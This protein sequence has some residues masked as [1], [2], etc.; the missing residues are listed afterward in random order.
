MRFSLLAPSRAVDLVSVNSEP[1]GCTWGSPK[2]Q[3]VEGMQGGLW[4]RASHTAGSQPLPRRLPPPQPGSELFQPE[5]RKGREKVRVRDAAAADRE[6]ITRASPW[7]RKGKGRA[8][9]GGPSSHRRARRWPG[10]APLATTDVP[11]GP[12]CA[13]CLKLSL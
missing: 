13:T 10:P 2:A 6:R 7:P 11:R 8:G 9:Q 4:R 3:Q 5:A 1:C 12:P